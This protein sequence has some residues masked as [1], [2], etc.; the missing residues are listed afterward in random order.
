[1][2][3]ILKLTT[4]LNNNKIQNRYVKLSKILSFIIFLI[5]NFTL[6]LLKNHKKTILG[7]RVLSMLY[8]GLREKTNIALKSS[9][10]WYFVIDYFS[11]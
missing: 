3:F 7:E 1:L 8:V 6:R 10:S 5:C 11:I 9:E 4:K 2:I